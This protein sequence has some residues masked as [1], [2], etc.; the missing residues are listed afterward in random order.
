MQK[1]LVIYDFFFN[2]NPAA[3]R[4]ENIWSG[5]VS[6]AVVFLVLSLLVMPNGKKQK[7]STQQM[8]HCILHC[9]LLCVLNQ[10]L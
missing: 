7:Y 4:E 1:L 9:C 8:L 5:M 2:R 10:I 6:L 3:T